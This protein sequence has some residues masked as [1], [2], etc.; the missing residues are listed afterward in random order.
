MGKGRIGKR[1]NDVTIIKHLVRQEIGVTA[2]TRSADFVNHSS[3]V[4]AGSP[5]GGTGG[6]G[7]G[8]V[9]SVDLALP[10]IFTISGNPIT[11]SGTITVGM[12]TQVANKFFASPDGSTGAP[13]FRSIVGDDLPIFTYTTDGAVPAPTG[14][15]AVR[16]LREDGT[17]QTPLLTN[18]AGSTTQIQYNNAGAFGAS[19]NLTFDSAF[20]RLVCGG[21]IE[22]GTGTFITNKARMY[23]DSSLGTVFTSRTGSTYDIAFAN[24]T[25]SIIFC[26]PT[27]TNNFQILNG[28]LIV[29]SFGEFGT[30][31][32]ISG[33]GYAS[34]QARMYYDGS[35]GF[36][37]TGSRA[38]STNDFTL[39]AR[40]GTV[41][42]RNPTNTR[43]VEFTNGNVSVIAGT[44]AGSRRVSSGV[45]VLT[46]GATIAL[47]ASL[48]NHFRVTLGGNRTLGV[49]TNPID[50][51]KI[52]IEIIQDA[53]GS[54]TLTLTTGS[55]D[56]F[57][58]GTDITSITLTTTPSKR[59]L[60]GAIYSSS[61]QR[62]MVVSFIKGF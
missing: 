21:S 55:T 25:G 50:G 42:F 5:V 38:G 17:W 12:T 26:N 33:G 20:N 51:Q 1:A 59:D 43:N 49:P 47:D 44:I 45:S 57:V 60:L 53:T 18:P 40:N 7:S 41:I 35:L 14:A 24:S 37:V 16:F 4:G 62:W 39:I 10:G 15:G 48:G 52:T 58:F 54:R 30:Y 13:T 23:Y 56:S 11:T 6:G 22:A 19:A 31:L 32:Q 2:T 61:L 9:T 34:G 36:V 28:G 8:T 3:F 27:S 29:N 46:D